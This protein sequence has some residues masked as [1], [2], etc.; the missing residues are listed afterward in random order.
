MLICYLDN[1][2][3]PDVCFLYHVVKK[4]GDKELSFFYHVCLVILSDKDIAPVEAFLYF[5]EW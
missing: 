5:L 2:A 3:M 4:I 1:T